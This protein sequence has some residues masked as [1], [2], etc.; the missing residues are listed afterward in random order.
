[1]SE[2]KLVYLA[3]PYTHKDPKIMEERFQIVNKIAGGLINK[4]EIVFSPISHCHPIALVC[5]LPKD[6]QYWNTF[7]RAYMSCCCEMYVVMLDGW[8]ES[9]GIQAEIKIA[10]EMGIE[11]KYLEYCE[12]LLD[13]LDKT[14][15]MEKL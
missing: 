8:K 1:M 5:D 13:F 11:I 3:V 4:G 15:E 7:C 2:K 12:S 14:K 6:W 9:I 10:E